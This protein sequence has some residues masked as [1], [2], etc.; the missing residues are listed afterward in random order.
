MP[1]SAIW[2]LNLPHCFHPICVGVKNATDGQALK[3]FTLVNMFSPSGGSVCLPFICVTT[4]RENKCQGSLKSVC[5]LCI[6]SPNVWYQAQ[7][8]DKLSCILPECRSKQGVIPALNRP[9]N[10]LTGLSSK[11]S[12]DLGSLCRADCVPNNVIVL[13]SPP[14][15]AVSHG[16]F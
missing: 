8:P 7:Q 12:N 3:T 9:A 14:F 5:Y 6:F 11:P 2:C 4:C 16:T 13:T 1:P 15:S 10:R